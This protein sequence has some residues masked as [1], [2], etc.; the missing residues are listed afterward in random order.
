MAGKVLNK[1]YSRLKNLYRK[2]KFLNQNTKKLLASALVQCHYDYSCSF[3]YSS[4]SKQ[5]KS[6][7]QISQNKLVRFTLNL[8][9]R[10]HLSSEHFKRLGWLPIEQR[11][12]Q[13]KLHHVYRV[14]DGKA[15]LY[16]S[17]HF[18]SSSTS[19]SQILALVNSLVIPHHNLYNSLPLGSSQS[20]LDFK[21]KV[22]LCIYDRVFLA[23]CDDFYFYY[24]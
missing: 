12:E 1:V 22:K 8:Q 4:L 13:L 6:K 10:T 24:I 2:S 17:D 19:H 3:W 15:P 9:P 21:K 11:V 18:L 14:L 5:T 23:E 20:L 16:L 7:L